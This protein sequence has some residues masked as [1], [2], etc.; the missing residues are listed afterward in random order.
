M[1]PP[2][3]T[4]AALRR[5]PLLLAACLGALLLAGVPAGATEATPL[6]PLRLA[7]PWPDP[8]EIAGEAVRIDSASPFVPA[9]MGP[10]APPATAEVTWY[11]P[12]TA[13]GAPPAP[14]VVLLHGASGVLPARE[15]AYARQLAAMGVG[16][17]V[18]DVFGA[19]RDRGGGFQQRLLEI[20]E[21]MAM[22]D[23]FATLG[24]LAARPEI[25]GDRVVLWGFS[26]GAMA[27]L[28][29]AHAATAAR[30]AEAFGLGGRRFAGHIAFYGPCIA[31]FADPRTTGAPIL[32]AWGDEDALIDAAR[33]R[34]TADAFAAGGSAVTTAIYPGA[35]HQWDGG[36]PGPH[37][38]G[39]RLD[40]CDFR[41][42]PDLGVTA[43]PLSLPMTGPASR[44]LLLALCIGSEGYLLGADAA[45]RDRSNRDVAAFLRQAFGPRS[46]GG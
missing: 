39:R 28:Y 3:P 36:R 38:I 33:C 45:V 46:E 30:F 2:I 1:E 42:G 44:R 19:R 22:A 35:Y 41:I 17:A 29:A 25:D 13:E 21:T 26:Y 7:D 4:P 12:V 6:P 27:S 32:M 43:G 20:T 14:A 37:M 9:D 23:A 10:D 15:R 34:E 40:G 16:A 5:A 31:R 24:W 8:P 18:V 11:P